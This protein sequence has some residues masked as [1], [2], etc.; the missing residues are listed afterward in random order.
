MIS[1]YEGV[2]DSLSAE[3][4]EPVIQQYDCEDGGYPVLDFVISGQPAR[5]LEGLECANPEANGA[6]T[7]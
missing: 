1:Q 5:V 4:T 6:S 2:R 7:T 3:I